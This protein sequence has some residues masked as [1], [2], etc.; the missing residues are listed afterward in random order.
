MKLKA[1]QEL[2]MFVSQVKEHGEYP[3]KEHARCFYWRIIIL[4]YRVGTGIWR[5]YNNKSYFGLKSND[6]I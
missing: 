3:A 5:R 4:G 6:N 2:L 1:E